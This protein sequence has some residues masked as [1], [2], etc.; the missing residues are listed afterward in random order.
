VRRPPLEQQRRHLLLEL[1]LVPTALVEMAAGEEEEA[2]VGEVVAVAEEDEA[3]RAARRVE[4]D[5]AGG[6]LGGS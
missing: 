6:G 4:E 2:G 5:V 3:D 1:E